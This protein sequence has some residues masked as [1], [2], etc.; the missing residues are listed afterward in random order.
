MIDEMGG[1]PLGEVPHLCDLTPALQQVMD[2]LVGGLFERGVRVYPPPE[3]TTLP[4]R[5]GLVRCG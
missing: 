3:A 2:V 5:C 4:A 1:Q